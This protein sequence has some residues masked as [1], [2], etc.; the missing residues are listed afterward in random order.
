MAQ[1]GVTISSGTTGSLKPTTSVASW[2]EA[3]PARNRIVSPGRKKPMSRPVSAKITIQRA[4]RP[5]VCSSDSGL[6]GFSA[7]R[8]T[9][10]KAISGPGPC[11]LGVAGGA[12]LGGAEG[13]AVGLGRLGLGLGRSGRRRVRRRD[14]G[15][16]GGRLGGVGLGGGRLE[17]RAGGVGLGRDLDLQQVRLVPLGDVCLVAAAQPEQ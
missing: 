3:M 11:R 10:E 8:V 13:L 6:S 9:I 5:A 17:R 14:R 4:H 15:L 12:V 2:E 1:I 16:G 7:M